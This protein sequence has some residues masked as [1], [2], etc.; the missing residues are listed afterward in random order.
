MCTCGSLSYDYDLIVSDHVKEQVYKGSVLFV[1]LGWPTFVTMYM[2]RWRDIYTSW[3][4]SQVPVYVLV[5]HRL[6]T[7]LEEELRRLFRFLNEPSVTP[8]ISCV[9]Q[10]REGSHHR[11]KKLEQMQLAVFSD[12]QVEYLDRAIM[13]VKLALERK[14]GKNF[15]DFT[16][17]MRST[18]VN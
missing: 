1:L 9:V 7:N 6:V 3:A 11:K 15:S 14:T 5:Y 4:D 16:N 10:R 12:Q 18:S 13:E 17:W 8:Q 2:R